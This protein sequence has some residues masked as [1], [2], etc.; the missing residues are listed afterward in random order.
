MNKTITLP[1]GHR[2][3]FLQ[4]GLLA[5]YALIE[6]TAPPAIP[7]PPLHAHRVTDE[8]FYVIGGTFGFL[9]G[10][11]TVPGPA[12]AYVLVPAGQPHTFWNAGA[13]PATVLIVISPPGFEAYF[14]ELAERLAAA[15]DAPDANLSVRQGLS[16]KYDI[17]VLG[18]AR[19]GGMDQG[20]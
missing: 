7:G 5:R 13:T 2:L 19:G 12:G 4:E 15:G 20:G 17:E 11:E 16:G 1:D 18:P 8:G 6:W 10:D 14:D 3:R 9:I